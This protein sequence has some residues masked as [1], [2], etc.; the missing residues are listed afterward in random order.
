[1]NALIARLLGGTVCTIA[2]LAVGMGTAHAEGKAGLN[3]TAEVTTKAAG[4]KVKVAPIVVK[5]KAPA[6]RVRVA[7]H[8]THAQPPR[9]TAVKARTGNGA[10]PT[11]QARVRVH[12]G[13]RVTPRPRHAPRAKAVVKIAEGAAGEGRSAGQG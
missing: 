5:V 13:S 1:M 2:V 9:R 7:V 8:A 3:I 10:R 12:T 4:T 11:A 6:V